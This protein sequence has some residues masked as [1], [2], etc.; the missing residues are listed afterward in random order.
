MNIP[1]DSEKDVYTAM[2]KDL[3]EAIE[4]LTEKAENGVS[5]MKNYDAVYAG[6]AAK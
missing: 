5:I 6:D 2:F 3:T 1:F 4:V